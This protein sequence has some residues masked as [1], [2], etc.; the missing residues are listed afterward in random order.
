[1]D[2]SNYKN[3]SK[4]IDFT[5]GQ[6]IINA[7]DLVICKYGY[8]FISECLAY[9]TKFRYLLE[10]SHIEA[11]NIHKCLQQKGLQNMFSLD[12]IKNLTINDELIHNTMTYKITPD[13]TNIKNA[14]LRLL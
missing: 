5:E 7:S 13:N 8:G 9:G 4:Q 14:I 1:M 6:N 3:K 2:I 12:K 10:P 11:Y